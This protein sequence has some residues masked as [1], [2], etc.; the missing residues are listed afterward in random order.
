M[1]TRLKHLLLDIGDTEQF[2]LDTFIAGRTS[3]IICA[4]KSGTFIFPILYRQGLEDGIALRH[5]YGQVRSGG[6]KPA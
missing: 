5:I 2:D 6:G 3:R 1:E 4:A